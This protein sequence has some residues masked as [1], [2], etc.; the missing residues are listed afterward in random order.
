MQHSFE[1][2]LDEMNSLIPGLTLFSVIEG[3][4]KDK[5]PEGKADFYRGLSTQVERT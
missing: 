5:N 4:R 2:K 1:E 3:Y